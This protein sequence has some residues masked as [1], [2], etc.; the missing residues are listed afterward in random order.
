MPIMTRI[1]NPILRPT[2][3]DDRGLTTAPKEI[4]VVEGGGDIP[5][6]RPPII[7][8]G[9]GDVPLPRPPIVGTEESEDLFGTEGNDE[10]YG[11]GG[12]DDIDG[13]KGADKMYGG[14]G[15]DTYVVDDKNDIVVENKDEGDDTVYSTSGYHLGDNVEN[16]KL[17]GQDAINGSGNELNNYLTGNDN[18]NIL[19][20]NGG[21]DVLDGGKGADLMI[22]GD[23][24][25]IYFVDD[26]GDVILEFAGQ[27][28]W[29]NVYSSI[30]YEL[31]LGLDV[32]H[33]HLLEQGGAI[34]GTGNELHNTIDGNSSKNTLK[35]GA[36]NDWID[37]KGGNDTMYGGE[38]DDTFIVDSF[39]DVVVE[40]ANQGSYDKV[41]STAT[42]FL[43]SNVEA[44][45]LQE[46]GGAIN[47][48][49]NDDAEN[50]L[51][52]NSFAND[53]GGYG[54]TDYIN[55]G[56]GKD[57]VDGGT[58]N[59]YLTGGSGNDTFRFHGTFGND[60][61]SDFK[62]G[63]DHDIIELD[64][65]QFAD[66]AAVQAAMVQGNGQTTIML[67][68]NHSIVLTGVNAADLQA[69]DFQFV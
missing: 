58:G 19:F 8:Q 10:I 41:H 21:R 61:I 12:H 24:D 17:Q 38:D 67:D 1:Q 34:D 3:V 31:G 46:E 59:D 57:T 65:N 51:T 33:L 64:H 18:I 4:V 37:G 40:Y 15:D 42:H 62:A 66:F 53:L 36:G 22:G 30:S 20:G 50:F 7:I 16:L 29:D 49:G 25:D 68:A 55:A 13:R 52:G 27:G 39:N 32:E 56:G 23:D 69:S 54:G 9:G 48:Y 35:G 26:A 5:L 45:F 14:D 11:L 6:P 44:L 63:G 28:T 47:G 43:T 60:Q 2:T